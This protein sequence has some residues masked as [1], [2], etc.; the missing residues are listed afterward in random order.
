LIDDLQ[1]SLFGDRL[2]SFVPGAHKSPLFTSLKEKANEFID[3]IILHFREVDLFH[4][5]RPIAHVFAD[6]IG[7]VT[8]LRGHE[9]KD[10]QITR[11]F[12]IDM[13]SSFWKENM[14]N[15]I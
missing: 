14:G 4:T 10:Q 13:R 3:A 8:F 11:Q 7:C 1:L 15:L 9:A 6:L 2:D 12:F 5:G